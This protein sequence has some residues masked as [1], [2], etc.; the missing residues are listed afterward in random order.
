MDLAY[1]WAL[2]P[3]LA[4]PV[5]M[6][7]MGWLMMRMNK[8]QSTPTAHM[9]EAKAPAVQPTGD[10]NVDERLAAL[11]TQLGAVETRGAALAAHLD[12]LK[13]QGYPTGYRRSQR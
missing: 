10:P 5:G 6:G 8:D 13:A 1:L 7:L 11:R 9:P 2:L 12:R 4:C 3:F